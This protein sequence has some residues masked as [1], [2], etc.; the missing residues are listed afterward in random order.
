MASANSDNK[1][2]RERILEVAEEIIARDGIEG[3]RLRDLAEPIGIRVPS[4]YAHFR[5]REDVLTG[6]AE[7]YIAHLTDQ[8]PDDGGPDAMATLDKGVRRYA[9]FLARHTAYARLLLRDMAVGGMPELKQASGGT[10]VEHIETGPLAPMHQRVRDI[11]ARGARSGQFRPIPIE[12]FSRALFG[13][14]LVS[15]AYPAG[16][17]ILDG[18][19]QP[20]DIEAAVDEIAESVRRVVLV[21]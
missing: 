19:A 7:R 3:M 2:T 6:V 11:L 13:L 4:I 18:G 12:V 1:S 17:S 16:S 20:A 5:G 14:V 10:M 15:L 9:E 21:L 8:F